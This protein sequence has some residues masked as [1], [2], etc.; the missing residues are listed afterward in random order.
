MDDDLPLLLKTLGDGRLLKIVPLTLGRAR[1]W[2]VV[3]G[4]TIDH[5]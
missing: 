5:Y 2:V 3:D 1:I 4:F